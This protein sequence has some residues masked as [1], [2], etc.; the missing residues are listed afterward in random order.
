MT[1]AQLEGDCTFIIVFPTESPEDP[2]T[3]LQDRDNKPG[4][5]YPGGKCF[6]G[7]EVKP[8][9]TPLDA[10]FRELFEE[11]GIQRDKVTVIPIGWYR[12][13]E[14]RPSGRI[15]NDALFLVICHSGDQAVGSF[16][17]KIYRKRWSKVR[18]IRK[19]LAFQ[20][21]LVFDLI[22]ACLKEHGFLKKA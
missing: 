11:T 9:E 6:P 18:R 5:L 20:Q 3:V 16:E 7:G 14:N 19:Q 4:I 1:T 12:H 13:K 15:D 22:E 8:G 17:G 10:L 2:Y 21:G